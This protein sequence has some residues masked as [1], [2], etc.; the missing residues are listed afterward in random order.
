VAALRAVLDVETPGHGFARDGRPIILFEPHIFF[1]M[2]G[3]GAK[4]DW[5][6]RHGLAA[7]KWGSIAYPGRQDARYSQLERAAG[8]DRPAAL[9]S[10][11][12]GLGQVMGFNHRRAGHADIEAFVEAMARSEADQLAAMACFIAGGSLIHALRKQDWAAFARGY[13]GSGYAQNRYDQKLAIACRKHKRVAERPGAIIALAGQPL[14]TRGGMRALQRA[15]RAGGQDPGQIDGYWGAKTLAATRSFQVRIGLKV[16]HG[17]P[18]RATRRALE[19]VLTNLAQDRAAQVST[20]PPN[21][22]PH[23]AE[24]GIMNETKPWYFSRGV[25]G[26]LVTVGASI[27]GIFGLA[28]EPSLTEQVGDQLLLIVT[29]VGGLVSL[30]GR[31][32]ATQR[33][34]R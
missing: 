23:T 22:P 1:R 27:G 6:V 7:A 9:R 30:L 5:A 32:R 29:A 10:A 34:G 4:Q 24:D 26:A 14:A 20:P 31:M 19:A 11:S 13:N 8:I 16:P 33:I 12:W 25:I 17:V 21:T 3:P 28:V 2:L 18:D 15:L